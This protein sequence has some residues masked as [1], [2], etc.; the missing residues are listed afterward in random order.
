MDFYK[1]LAELGFPMAAALCAGYFVYLTLKFILAGVISN[2]KSIQ[3]IILSL[4]K[5]IKTMDN[6]LLKIDILISTALDLPPD[7]ERISR[8]NNTDEFR[9]D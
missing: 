9:K 2:I 3:G 5:R 7:V 4:D 8:L 1:L 6:D